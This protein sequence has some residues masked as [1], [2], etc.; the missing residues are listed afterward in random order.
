MT[1]TIASLTVQALIANGIDQLYCPGVQNDHFFNALFDHTD[2]ITPIQT[3]HERGGLCAGDRRGA[4]HWRTA[5]L[6][7]RAGT[8]LP[9]HH[10]RLVH[11]L[12]R[13]TPVMSWSGRS[14]RRTGQGHGLLH[15]IPDQIGIL[16]RLTKSAHRIWEAKMPP[17]PSPPHFV[18]LLRAPRPV[19]W[20]SPSICGPGCR[21]R[22]RRP[23]AAG[24]PSPE[25][26]G[27]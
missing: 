15:E 12:S 21:R 13:S 3:R 26:D 1:T 5:G 20:K 7:R 24:H 11:R 19:G 25:P 8:R 23:R 14:H 9:E 6:L 27:D 22:D 16:E 17:P 4:G 18:T 10:S 2:M